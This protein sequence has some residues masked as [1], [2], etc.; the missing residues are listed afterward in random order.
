M[1]ITKTIRTSNAEVVLQVICDN[2]LELNH[3]RSLQSALPVFGS[4]TILNNNDG[5]IISTRWNYETA[6]AIIDVIIKS[7]E[8]FVINNVKYINN[9][10]IEHES[11]V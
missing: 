1:D 3:L 6:V 10:D 11:A 9:K 4:L 7:L 8:L 5:V 2:V